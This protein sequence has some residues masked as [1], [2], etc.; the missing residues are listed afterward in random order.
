MNT[1]MLPL[2]LLIS[3]LG[4]AAISAQTIDFETLPDG[5]PTTDGMIISNQYSAAYGVSFQFEDG[6]YPQIAK[7]GKPATAFWG[8]PNNSTADT[9]AAGQN[10]GTSFLTDDGN[11]LTGPKSALIISYVTAVSNVSGVLIDIDFNESWLIQARDSK[12]NVI[13]SIELT[14]TSYNAGDGLATP[15]AFHHQTADIA[16]V[17]IVFTGSGSTVGLAFDN[18]SPASAIT[19]GPASLGIQ[20]YP[21]LTITGTVSALYRIDYAE[22][23]ET[24]TWF[25]LDTILL[26][27]SPYHWCDFT[28]TNATQRFY[29]AVGIQ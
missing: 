23:P 20:F 14:K 1:K 18:F 11:I 6:T 17:G 21:G 12:S 2:T 3:A 15:W 27:H 19:P 24:N 4:A 7:V 22:A 5:S 25:P 29:R 8:P 13:D 9:P 10:V 28:A 26:T 16:S